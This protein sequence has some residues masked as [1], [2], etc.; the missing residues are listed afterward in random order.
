[1][2]FIA[3]FKKFIMRGNVLDLAV[4]VVI[5]GAFGKI[6]GSLVADVLMPPIG[7]IAGKIDFSNLFLNLGEGEYATLKAAK[8]A[9]APTI[10]YGVFLTTLIDFL[11]IAFAVF[12]LVKAV[13]KLMEKKEEPKPAGPPT[14][15]ECQFCCSTIPI[16]ATKCM[17]CTSALPA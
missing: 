2:P 8:E 9:G 6:T 10:N 16:K 3:E 14:T 12:L 11:I 1:M 13:N 15:K 5:G 17:H 4:G 7:L